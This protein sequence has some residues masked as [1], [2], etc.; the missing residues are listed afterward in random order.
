MSVEYFLLK[1]SFAFHFSV[2][3]SGPKFSKGRGWKK[4]NQ[5]PSLGDASHTTVDASYVSDSQLSEM[6]DPSVLSSSCFN[7]KDKF[8]KSSCCSND[9]PKDMMKHKDLVTTDKS[10]DRGNDDRDESVSNRDGSRNS[11]LHEKV[12]KDEN[13]SLSS[14]ISGN[15]SGNIFDILESDLMP[16][17]DRLQSMKNKL[18]DI[19]AAPLPS[20]EIEKEIPASVS[21]R[22]P[23]SESQQKYKELVEHEAMETEPSSDHPDGNGCAEQGIVSEASPSDEA[24]ASETMPCN[25]SIICDASQTLSISPNTDNPKPS[26]K[27][28]IF[29]MSPSCRKLR[30]LETR[31]YSSSRLRKAFR[32]RKPKQGTSGLSQSSQNSVRSSQ[33]RKP[34]QDTSGTSQ[35][36]QTNLLCDQEENVIVQN[37]VESATSL[38]N[39]SVAEPTESGN[40]VSSSCGS[41]VSRVVPTSALPQSENSSDD[42]MDAGYDSG[43]DSTPLS[44]AEGTKSAAMPGHLTVDQS[45]HKRQDISDLA[46]KRQAHQLAL[47]RTLQTVQRVTA[48]LI[49]NVD[50]ESKNLCLY[51][52]RDRRQRLQE[53]DNIYAVRSSQRL[54]SRGSE[55]DILND[56]QLP[57][58]SDILNWTPLENEDASADK[59]STSGEVASSVPTRL[60]QQY[61]CPPPFRERSD[62]LDSNNA[63]ETIQSF[64]AKPSCSQKT[65]KQNK[66]PSKLCNKNSVKASA[67][68]L[69]R[70]KAPDI[71]KLF[72][73]SESDENG[74]INSCAPTKKKSKYEKHRVNGQNKQTIS[75]ATNITKIRKEAAKFLTVDVKKLQLGSLQ[76]KCLASSGYEGSKSNVIKLSKDKNISLD[77]CIE[78]GK[79]RSNNMCPTKTSISVSESASMEGEECEEEEKERGEEEEDVMVK[80]AAV[81]A[82]RDGFESEDSLIMVDQFTSKQQKMKAGLSGVR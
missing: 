3:K 25:A 76:K 65:S 27:S 58:V 69:K 28:P 51:Q 46:K 38:S 35:S 33:L 70:K 12:V 15:T 22:A 47:K 52:K 24:D 55:D 10:L 74:N 11:G 1:I 34:K 78:I 30:L 63:F 39:D 43:P 59:S 61:S 31:T 26:T 6:E 66:K 60:N 53:G 82:N 81:M 80:P 64:R 41:V 75:G 71:S 73:D 23:P 56:S 21:A 79:N 57:A 2:S 14:K 77:D 37:Q 36:S 7:I 17:K 13:H 19:D 49:N 8:M 5:E 68:V 4:L 48:E 67:S 50:E 42:S 40:A 9:V 44:Q 20:D 16:L 62:S 54:A 18:V 32:F 72:S 45:E 29:G